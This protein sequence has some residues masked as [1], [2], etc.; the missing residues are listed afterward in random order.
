MYIVCTARCDHTTRQRALAPLQQ[1][2]HS[3]T[4]TMTTQPTTEAGRP[5]KRME[6]LMHICINWNRG[7][8][9]RQD[10]SFRHVCAGCQKNHKAR[11]CPDLPVE[12]EY[13][14]ANRVQINRTAARQQTHR[15]AV[16]S[17]CCHKFHHLSTHPLT[18]INHVAVDSIVLVPH[19][20]GSY[21]SVSFPL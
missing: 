7:T 3:T 11:F 19:I 12:S 18:C 20:I 17:N 9:N 15:T 4:F 13:K 21:C 6:S 8:C 5:P 14:I 16:I 1:Q 2:L 10:C